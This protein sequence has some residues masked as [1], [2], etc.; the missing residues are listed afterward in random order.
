ME[1]TMTRSVR[2]LMHL[3]VIT[4]PPESTLGQAAALLA[5]H[6]IHAIVV[7][8]EHGQPLGILSDIDLLTG[9][10]LST[11]EA[12][13]QAMRRM[14]AGEMMSAPPLTIDAGAGAAEA[15]QRMLQGRIHRLLVMDQGVPVGIISP[16]D[17]I[18]GLV[19]PARSRATVADVMSRG[20]VV[21][22]EGTALSAVARAMTE[23]RSRSVVIV[24][25]RGSPLGV[26]TGT[27]VLAACQGECGELLVDAY[28]HPP[29][30]ILP[31]ASL[32]AAADRMIHHHVHRLVVVEAEDPDSMP[33]GLISTTDIVLA[34]AGPGSVWQS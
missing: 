32:Q 4:C 26:V 25:G 28:M 8:D 34:M 18:A 30:T 19:P 29:L 11:D 20:L 10:W 14:T 33:L 31:G 23:R 9:E 13:L 24:N 5:R 7:A 1:T 27:D 17:F 3:G 16:S 12:G 2:E 22:R 6:R 15:R 21:C